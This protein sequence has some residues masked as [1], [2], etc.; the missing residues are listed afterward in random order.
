[1]KLTKHRLRKN[2]FWWARL[3]VLAALFSA[4][5]LVSEANQTTFGL[6]SIYDGGLSYRKVYGVSCKYGGSYIWCSCGLVPS[7]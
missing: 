4:L 7:L 5:G 1:M 6:R 2:S 3:T